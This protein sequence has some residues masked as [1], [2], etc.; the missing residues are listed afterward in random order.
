[1]AHWHDA[2]LDEADPR[3]GGSTRRGAATGSVRPSTHDVRVS[4]SYDE[5]RAHGLRAPT[6]VDAAQAAPPP[7]PAPDDPVSNAASEPLLVKNEAGRWEL[8]RAPDEEPP[9]AALKRPG[10]ELAAAQRKRMVRVCF[11]NTSMR[12][13]PATC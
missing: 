1:M 8:Q 11:A 4:V 10:A 9:P 13:P 5:L 12:Q 6:L 2:A 3:E 7:P